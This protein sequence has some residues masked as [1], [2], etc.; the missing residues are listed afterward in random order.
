MYFISM[1]VALIITNTKFQ[2]QHGVANKYTPLTENCCDNY[3]EIDAIPS[4]KQVERTQSYHTL[5]A[6][7]CLLSH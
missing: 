5:S 1:C 2:D 7:P 4:D 3:M 6:I